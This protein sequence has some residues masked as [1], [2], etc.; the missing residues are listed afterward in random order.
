MRLLETELNCVN[1]ADNIDKVYDI[2]LCWCP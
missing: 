1:A 2:S